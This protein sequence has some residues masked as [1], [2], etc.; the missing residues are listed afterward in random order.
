VTTQQEAREALAVVGMSTSV[1]H[2]PFTSA[3]KTLAAFID[4]PPASMVSADENVE[5]HRDVTYPLG[6][7]LDRAMTAALCGET[8]P[9]EAAPAAV[10]VPDEAAIDT[11]GRSLYDRYGPVEFARWDDTTPEVRLHWHMEAKV[12]LSLIGYA[13]LRAEVRAYKDAVAG[14]SER[15]EAAEAERDQWRN[16]AQLE[17]NEAKSWQS[18]AETAEAERDALRGEVERLREQVHVPGE[19]KCAKCGFGVTC[20]TLSAHDGSIRPNEAPQQCANGCGPLWR[21]TE[22]DR[23]REAYGVID[24]WA[25]R[26]ESA[27]RDR[28]HWKA[29]HDN[30]VRRARVLLERTDMPLERVSAYKQLEEADIEIADLHDR[31]QEQRESAERELAEVRARLARVMDGLTW[32]LGANGDFRRQ[33]TMEGPY[34][35]RGELAERA[36]V[37]WN[38]EAYIHRPTD[39]ARAQQQ[40]GGD[41][42]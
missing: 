24:Q 9:A 8:L 2:I 40:G 36:G 18:R 14:H 26:A 34:W 30:Q 19:W 4:Q 10:P 29:N 22:R 12:H 23:R 1:R 17:A 20:S 25:E 28:D 31:L 11:L 32:A 21:V 7:Q 41:E 15:W 37:F 16:T 6:F 13:E 35:W 33:G 27:E 5:P 39:A 42:R 38:G 3:M